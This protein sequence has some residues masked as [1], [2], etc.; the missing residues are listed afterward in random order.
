MHGRA[1]WS[2]SKLSINVHVQVCLAIPGWDGSGC[3]FGCSKTWNFNEFCL[4]LVFWKGAET[5]NKIL[6]NEIRQN[7]AHCWWASID[8]IWKDWAAFFIEK[9]KNTCHVKILG[10]NQNFRGTEL[11]P[12]SEGDANLTYARRWPKVQTL[13]TSKDCVSSYKSQTTFRW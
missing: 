13:N 7:E 2:F 5:S 10:Q 4:K 1:N 11:L 9:K 3:N 8:F 12:S 6:C